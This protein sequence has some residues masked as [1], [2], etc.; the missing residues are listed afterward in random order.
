M[1]TELTRLKGGATQILRALVGIA[2]KAKR[3][4]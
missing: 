2:E 4:A 1:R 3:A